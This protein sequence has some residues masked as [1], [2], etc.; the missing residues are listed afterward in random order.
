MYKAPMQKESLPIIAALLAW[1]RRRRRNLPWREH[2]DPYR[3]WISE[4]MLQQTQ[5]DTVI[6]YYFRFLERFPDV[7]ALAAAQPDD[8]LKAW[9]NLGYYSRARHLH[10]TAGILVEQFH[11]VIPDT[12]EAIRALPGV[13]DYTAGAILSIAFG[14]PVAA[15]DGNV[16]RVLSR[17]YAVREPVNRRETH[18]KINALAAA[19]VPEDEPGAFNQ[20]L[21]ELG[22]LVC[23]PKSP[24]C[25]NCPLGLHCL[26]RQNGLQA[27]LPFK[28]KKPPRPQKRVVA[29]VIFNR[30]EQALIVRR[31]ARGLLGSLWKFPG[32]VVEKEE[33]LEEG[34]A[35]T[36]QEELGIRVRIGTPLASIHHAYT[37]FRITL[38][39]FRCFRR[40]GRLRALTCQ[41]WRWASRAELEELALSKADRAVIPAMKMDGIA[42]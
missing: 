1:Y 35:R 25:G 33:M 15:V 17:L 27:L 12:W 39:A 5:V 3:I 16:R 18:K 22:A 24:A 31:P 36:I 21:M 30:K 41:E 32:G 23:T 14:K 9:E 29:A 11:G 6:P 8:V 10:R 34:L 19:L 7:A 4:I 2:P 42:G 28:E 37:H 13:G 40:S 38:T 20:A 26:A